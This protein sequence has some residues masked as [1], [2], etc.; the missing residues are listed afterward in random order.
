MSIVHVPEDGDQWIGIDLSPLP[1]A[2]AIQWAARPDCG[3]VV[4]FCGTVRDH[5]EGRPGVRAL[6]YEAY[7]EEAV[8]RL[9]RIAAEVRV[10]WPAVGRVALLHRTGLLA[11]GDTAVVVVVST[12]HRAE[13]FRAAEW[14][15]DT[16]KST[17]PIW[18]KETWEGG[19]D[20]GTGAQDVA[21]VALDV[22]P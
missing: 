22:S 19:S 10:R 2:T 6:E 14:A 13:A 15:I 18:K 8:A 12:P 5:A 17:V 20:W 11:V 1:V 16:I 3:G 9:D 21:E 7:A 4:A